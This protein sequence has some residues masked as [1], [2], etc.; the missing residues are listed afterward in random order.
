MGYLLDDL[1]AFGIQTDQDADD[2][3]KP[4]VLFIVV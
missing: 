2:G 1:K 4:T 3:N